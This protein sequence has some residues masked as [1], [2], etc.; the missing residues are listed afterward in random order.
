MN[1]ELISEINRF[2]EIAGLSL[3]N[4]GPGKGWAVT[5]ADDLTS[6]LSKTSSDF[7]KGLDDLSSIA[8]KSVDEINDP[9]LK[10][11]K[12]S[13]DEIVT[14]QGKS[15]DEIVNNPTYRKLVEK[16]F[17]VAVKS[18]EDLIKKYTQSY[19]KK[20]KG[21]QQL[22]DKK[23]L[24]SLVSD[25]VNTKGIRDYDQL[26]QLFYKRIDNFATDEGKSIPDVVKAEMRKIID[27]EVS[28]MT[29]KQTLE[30]VVTKKLDDLIG[31]QADDIVSKA[32]L[33]MEK[34][35]K[36]FPKP[37]KVT[38]EVLN[39]LK[40]GKNPDDIMKNIADEFGMSADEYKSGFSKFMNRY[41][42]SPLNSTWTW[43]W[44]Q[45]AKVI[46][47]YSGKKGGKRLWATVGLV[48]LGG[49][50]YGGYT[51]YKESKKPKSLDMWED[52]YSGFDDFPKEVKDWISNTYEYTTYRNPKNAKDNPSLFIKSVSYRKDQPD[53]N[54]PATHYITV[55]FGD[56]KKV[57]TES[58]D[59]TF[60]TD[61]PKTADQIKAEEEASKAAETA[62]VV[63]T[64]KEVT[65][66]TD[67]EKKKVI[68]KLGGSKDGY[69]TA[70]YPYVKKTGE[71]TFTYEEASGKIINVTLD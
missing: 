11:F 26:K 4:E 54:F 41:V 67:D 63:E 10:E 47:F 70:D 38:D 68:E 57:T 71:K 65:P 15:F 50:I 59:M 13:I 46:E 34:E 55:E 61:V 58:D 64:P 49:V 12:K 69:G 16:R 52:N 45:G 60:W 17:A 2:R 27:A 24:G 33:A 66:I 35:G 21:A 22:V 29:G 43:V 32:Q 53:P 28:S 56:G 51:Y 18:S 48:A 14:S 37:S 5:G 30:P 6:V 3:L 20:Y 8:G 31:K 25:A 19:F 44:N 23:L 40:A 7:K 62:K 36:M 1:K 39:D 9:F 42:G